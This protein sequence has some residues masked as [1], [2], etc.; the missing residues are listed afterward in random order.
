MPYERNDISCF[1]IFENRVIVGLGNQVIKDL[2][3]RVIER[4]IWQGILFYD[5][6]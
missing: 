4:E 3:D 1:M 6:V 5:V 2:R